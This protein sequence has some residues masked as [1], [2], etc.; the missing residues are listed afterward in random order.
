MQTKTVSYS[1][2]SV[3]QANRDAFGF[4]QEVKSI[5]A[6]LAKSLMSMVGFLNIAVHDYKEFKLD[7][8]E[9]ILERHICVFKDF[10]KIILQLESN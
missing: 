9:A 10:S 8:L 6:N 7:I 3:P 2:S 4:L 1:I 5:D